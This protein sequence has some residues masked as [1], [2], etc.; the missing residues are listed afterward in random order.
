MRAEV[1]LPSRGEGRARLEVTR[2]QCFRGLV[3]FLFFWTLR[4]G[5]RCEVVILSRP[6]TSGA[7]DVR[8][9]R[10]S[11]SSGKLGEE[12]YRTWKTCAQSDDK[13]KKRKHAVEACT[14]RS[15][16]FLDHA[17][18]DKERVGFGERFVA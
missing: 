9:Q 7:C 4:V 1:P 12:N 6:E 2:S 8:L 5:E 3:V 11:A 16:A 13:N 10:Q 14:V 15:V 17:L 18:C